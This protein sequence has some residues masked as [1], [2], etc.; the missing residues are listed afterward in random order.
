MRN[1]ENINF[2]KNKKQNQKFAGGWKF[3]PR[4]SG[5]GKADAFMA[6][7]ISTLQHPRPLPS[8]TQWE[9]AKYDFWARPSCC[10]F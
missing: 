5:E 1:K 2:I 4:M 10:L 9:F 8:I 7:T 3:E 6:A